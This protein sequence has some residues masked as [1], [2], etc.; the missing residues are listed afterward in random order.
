MEYPLVKYHSAG[1]I[2]DR[3]CFKLHG[4]DYYPHVSG[5]EIPALLNQG[6][7]YLILDIG[8]LEEADFSEFLRCDHKLVLGSLSPWKLWTYEEFFRQ[9]DNS[10]NLGEGFEYLVQAGTAK[11]ISHFSRAHRISMAVVPFIKNPFRIE[12]E[13]FLSF[14]S[15]LAAP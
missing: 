7:D 9:F 5:S 2:P 12:K 14:G 8:S 10:Q 13:L 6:Y 11:N 1:A 3:P 15:L 4:V